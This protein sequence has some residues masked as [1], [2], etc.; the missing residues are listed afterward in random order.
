MCVG[1]GVLKSN[2][3]LSLVF[4]VMVR[5]NGCHLQ[6]NTTGSLLYTQDYR[7][8]GEKY[9]MGQVPVTLDDGD[10]GEGKWTGSRPGL[11]PRLVFNH[12]SSVP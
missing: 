2:Q 11:M 6:V 3:Q 9:K 4:G 8:R 5:T 10:D 1:V 7:M 12:L